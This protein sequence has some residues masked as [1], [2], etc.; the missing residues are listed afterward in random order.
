MEGAVWPR[1]RG[2]VPIWAPL[3]T[4]VHGPR[5]LRGRDF[6]FTRHD[7]TKFLLSIL[8]FFLFAVG[9]HKVFKKFRVIKANLTRYF[10]TAACTV[11]RRFTPPLLFAKQPLSPTLLIVFSKKTHDSV[12]WWSYTVLWLMPA[13]LCC[14][15]PTSRRPGGLLTPMANAR[16]RSWGAVM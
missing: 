5:H 2:S 6:L 7:M 11:K 3:S 16:W 8:V 13:R 4:A 14:T 12:P 10:T 9:K 15:F 1:C